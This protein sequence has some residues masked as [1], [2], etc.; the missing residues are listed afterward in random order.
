MPR[1]LTI[2]TRHHRTGT[3]RRPARSPFTALFQKR[4]HKST[5]RYA[6]LKIAVTTERRK[7]TRGDAWLG[8]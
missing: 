8:R 4:S 1:T 5:S 6:T 7:S 2:R 3:A